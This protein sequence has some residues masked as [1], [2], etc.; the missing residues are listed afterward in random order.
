[1]AFPGWRAATCTATG[2]RSATPSLDRRS[3]GTAAARRTSS[4]STPEGTTFTSPAGNLAANKVARTASEI[5]TTI[6]TRRKALARRTGNTTRRV[7]TRRGGEPV[8][9]KNPRAQTA[10]VTA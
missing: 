4:G 5:A 1:A 8:Y 2:V 7:A 9:L 3:N 10:R 6:S